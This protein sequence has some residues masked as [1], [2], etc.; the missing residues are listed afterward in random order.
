MIFFISL[1]LYIEPNTF[2]FK[3]HYSQIA[4]FSYYYILKHMQFN[5]M[6]LNLNGLMIFF[7]F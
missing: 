7:T 5:V 6:Q 2:I 1:Q 4:S 3:N